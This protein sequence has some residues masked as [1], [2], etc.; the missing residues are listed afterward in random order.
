MMQSSN[1]KTDSVR[2]K[3]FKA[4][5]YGDFTPGEKLPT[6]R[7]MAERTGTSRVTVRRAYEQ[8]EQSGIL[9]REQGRGTFVSSYVGGNSK[10]G[11]QIALLSSVSDPFALEFIKELE[12]KLTVEDMLL[13][14]RIT[15][16]SAEKEEQAAIEL[17]GKGVNNLIIWPSGHEFAKGTFERLR[18]LGANMVFFDRMMPGSCAD[19]LGLN[20]DDAMKQLF[21]TAASRKLS[22]PVFVTHSDLFADSDKMRLEAFLKQCEHYQ[23]EG[24]VIELPQRGTVFSCPDIIGPESTV[25]CV[26]DAMAKKLEPFVDRDNLYGIDGL[27]DAKFVSCRQPMQD[28]AVAAVASLLNQQKKGERWK[29]SQKFIKGELKNV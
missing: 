22:A 13:I 23:V 19:Y 11:D 17:I 24:R 29:A 20:N 14:L 5:L 6:E 3:I 16:E 7:D 1:S 10:P 18:V 15:D 8:L 9:K 25:F 27:S 21:A 2:T 26:N 4:I 28:F 12:A